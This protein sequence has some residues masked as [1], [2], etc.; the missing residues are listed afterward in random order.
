MT[1]RIAFLLL[2]LLLLP[3]RADEPSYSRKICT[4]TALA[5]PY[6]YERDGNLTIS[7]VLDLDPKTFSKLGAVAYDNAGHSHGNDNHTFSPAAPGAAALVHQDRNPAAPRNVTITFRDLPLKDVKTI[8]IFVFCDKASLEQPITIELPA[9][10][11]TP[12]GKSA[13]LVIAHDPNDV[14]A[15]TT[16]TGLHIRATGAVD[17]SVASG[18]LLDARLQGAA[19]TTPAGQPILEAGRVEIRAT[20]APATAPSP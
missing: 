4:L 20:A 7:F 13:P 3:A 14:Q 8:D 15:L 11:G 12:T 5:A 16:S 17:T 19:V 1:Y 2:L 10:F 6:V 18:T 9:S